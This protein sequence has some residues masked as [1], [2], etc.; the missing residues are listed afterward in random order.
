MISNKF[1]RL[2]LA[3]LWAR[4]AGGPSPAPVVP[5][6]PVAQRHR[7]P[8]GHRESPA[9]RH[10]WTVSLSS[11]LLIPQRRLD[12]STHAPQQKGLHPSAVKGAGKVLPG[13][14]RWPRPSGGTWAPHLQEASG[15]FLH[16]PATPSLFPGDAG[17]A[18]GSHSLAVTPASDSQEGLR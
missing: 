2:V 12:G 18:A 6:G 16:S 4:G 14:R 5:A 8:P 11:P 17:S 9:D 10:A 7:R 15:P 13:A 1:R 3:S